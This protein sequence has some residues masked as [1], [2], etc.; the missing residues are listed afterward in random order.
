[1]PELPEVET[2]RQGL[3]EKLIGLQIIDL[4]IRAPKLFKG[5]LALILNQKVTGID[6]RG[7]L[8]IIAFSNKKYMTIHLKMTGQ[9]IW[10]SKDHEQ[11]ILGGHPEK[12]YLQTHPHKHTHLI[13]KLSDGSTLYYNDLRK[14]GV[15]KVL[16]QK[17]LDGE[18][19]L[20]GLGPEP[21][22]KEFTLGYLK[23]RI[24]SKP[25][26]QIKVF[27]LDQTNIAGL[28]N[29]YVDEALFRARLMPNRLNGDLSDGDIK[30]LYK[31]INEVISLAI[32]MGGST[33]RDYM[34][35]EGE[36]GKF[37]DQA[38]VYHKTGELCIV[39]GKNKIER[40]KVGGRSSH[41]CANCQK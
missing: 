35:I 12:Q 31:A 3:K 2:I 1:M 23:E 15:V 4:E 41:Y 19:F 13:F 27:L 34:N 24:K 9:L 33:A 5:D 21:L 32:E 6:R 18:S 22:S 26:N 25:R 8:L 38:N 10:Q 39:C 37:L 17:E 30:G 11:D 16:D 29:I 7:K 14:F 40:M 20:L 36:A 28:G